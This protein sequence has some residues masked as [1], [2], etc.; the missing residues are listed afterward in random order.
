MG[1]IRNVQ[2]TGNMHYVYLPT[3]WCKKFN[4]S[5]DSQ[6][7]IEMS[8]EGKL[9]ISA[10]MV[11]KKPK[12][13]ELNIDETDI[14]IINKLIVACYLSPAGS[15]KINLK[16]PLDQAKLLEQKRLVSIEL[17]EIEGNSITCESGITVA[18]PTLLLKT[19]ISKIRN[20]LMVMTGNYHK[21]LIERY[22]EE[23]DRNRTLINKSILS[24]LT[25]QS[26]MKTKIIDLF[27]ISHITRDLERVA[28]HIIRLDAG[29][30]EFLKLVL[31]RITLLKEI[32]ETIDKPKDFNYTSAIHFSK[33]VSDLRVEDRK[34]VKDYEKHRIGGYLISISEVIMDWTITKKIE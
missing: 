30:K 5:S 8:S 1:D 19:I 32:M 27:Y 22:E 3:S 15:F 6:V 31:E 18:D 13:L 7:Q 10:T 4:I 34:T 26:P 33:S 29:D 25:F 21:E 16:T 23:I 20:M 12:H 9:N 2:K 14:Q 28:D 17:V 11:E 24:S